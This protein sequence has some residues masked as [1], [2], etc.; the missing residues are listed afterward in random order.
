MI[1]TIMTV[2]FGLRRGSTTV[3]EGEAVGCVATTIFCIV[4]RYQGIK[5]NY[6]KINRYL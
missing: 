1:V 2:G 3:T 6:Y 4:I 5:H